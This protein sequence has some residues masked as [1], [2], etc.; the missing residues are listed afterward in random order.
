MILALKKIV[1]EVSYKKMLFLSIKSVESGPD[2]IKYIL[3]MVRKTAEFS[4][5]C[6]DKYHD[7]TVVD[8]NAACI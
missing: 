6:Y 7:N 2:E 1:S 4:A 3:N 8:Y 5:Y